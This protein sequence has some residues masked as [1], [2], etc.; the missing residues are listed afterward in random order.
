[1]GIGTD[2]AAAMEGVRASVAALDV[3][4]LEDAALASGIGAAGAGVDVLQR[5]YELCLKR[6]EVVS[7]LE[8]QLAAVKARDVAECVGLQ[9]AMTPP[10]APVDE[11]TFAEMSAMEEI[12]GVLTIS[13]GAAGAFVEQSRRVCSSPPVLG[14]L[15]SGLISWQHARIV[16]DETEGL[17]PCRC[18]RVGGAFLRPGRAQPGAGSGP[19]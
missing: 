10:D 2:L 3:L 16:A 5:R 14:A 6:L 4:V 18:C 7:R 8:A 13:S 15:S 19:G 12:A 11:R 9:Q 17:D 1:M